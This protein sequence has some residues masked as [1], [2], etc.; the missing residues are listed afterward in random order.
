MSTG[1]KVIFVG[2][3]SVGKTSIVQHIIKKN[4]DLTPTIGVSYYRKNI[5]KNGKQINLDIWD[6]SGQERFAKLNKFYYRGTKCCVLVFDLGNRE[7]FNKLVTWKNECDE[8]NHVPTTYLLVGNKNDREDII[9]SD[10]DIKRFCSENNI[11]KYINTCAHTGK[12]IEILIVFC[13]FY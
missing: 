10:I 7:S 5:T 8:T 6:T 11:V 3:A 1:I 13:T 12:N 2:Q 9:I 4:F